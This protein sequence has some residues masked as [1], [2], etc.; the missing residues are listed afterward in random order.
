MHFTEQD[1]R[2]GFFVQK[3]LDI[4]QIS[5]NQDLHT[6]TPGGRNLIVH[7]SMR[8]L[9]GRCHVILAFMFFKYKV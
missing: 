2:E 8:L 7:S 5:S 4:P 3:I 1:G 9:K 6:S